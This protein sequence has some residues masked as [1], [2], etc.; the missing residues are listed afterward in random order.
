M[1]NLKRLLII[2]AVIFMAPILVFADDM[3]EANREK[4]NVY[5]FKGATCHFCNDALEYIH[6]LDEEYQSYFNLVEYEVWNDA[7]NKEKMQKVSDYFGDN[8]S[9]VPYIIIGDFRFTNGFGPDTDGETFKEEVKK[10]YYDDNYVDVVAK[11][12]EEKNDIGFIIALTVVIVGGVAFVIFMSRDT[13]EKEE[14]TKKEVKTSK[15]EVVIK[16]GSSKPTSKKT[17]NNTKKSNKKKKK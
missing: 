1:K 4:I 6:G 10:A 9:G 13:E 11:I 5:M 16:E 2:I 3:P 17:N 7:S 8:A 12:L 15:D 14:K